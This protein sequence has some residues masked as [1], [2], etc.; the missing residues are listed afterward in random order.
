LGMLV[1]LALVVTFWAL[2]LPFYLVLPGVAVEERPSLGRAYNLAAGNKVRLFWCVVLVS[3]IFLVLDLIIGRI[4]RSFGAANPLM[5]LL[6]VPLNLFVLFFN[7]AS[8]TS[9]YAVAYRILSGLPDPR[10]TNV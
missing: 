3:A 1:S 8:T 4:G 7:V 9:V 2:A 6:L 5:A 10:I